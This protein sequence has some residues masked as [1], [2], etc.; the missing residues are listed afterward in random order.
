[1]SPPAPQCR[2]ADSDQAPAHWHVIRTVT[3]PSPSLQR[4]NSSSCCQVGVWLRVRV[5]SSV[6][7][8]TPPVARAA[9]R[10]TRTPTAESV[11][12]DS[13]TAAVTV[14]S[15]IRLGIPADLDS[16]PVTSPS[17]VTV[18]LTVRVMV[19]VTG[20]GPPLGDRDSE[21]CNSA[22][23]AVAGGGHW[24]WLAESGNRVTAAA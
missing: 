6:A 14:A 18:P 23:A 5:G 11:F 15:R 12:A 13:V 24:Q 3:V 22:W 16:E 10:P 8:L 21:K 1:M 9:V 4:L 20:R 19:T 17:H 7:R 2:W